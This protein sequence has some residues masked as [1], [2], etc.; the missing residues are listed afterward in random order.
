[1]KNRS[2][3]GGGIYCHE[4]ASPY[5]E[6]CLFLENEAQ[7]TGGGLACFFYSNAIIRR[8]IFQ[9][10][11]AG[12][13]GG[14][15][16]FSFSSPQISD[17]LIENNHA[18]YQGGGLY[19]SNTVTGAVSRITN[20]VLLS[21][22]SGKKGHNIFVTAKM[23]T[24]FR[25]N[26]L[27]SSGGF[28]VFV[29]ALDVDLDFVGNYFG[30]LAPGDLETHI[31]DRHD[32]PA[33]KTALCDPPMELPPPDA[34]NVP[35]E[36]S[37][38]QMHGDPGFATDWPYPLCLKAPIYLEVHAQDRNPYHADWV[39]IRLRSSASDPHGVVALAWET[40]PASGVF[41]LTGSVR[42]YSSAKEGAIRASVGENLLFNLEDHEGFEI[43]CPVDVAKSFITSL[44]LTEEADSLHVVSHSPV[45]GW[46]FRNILGLPQK[47]FR[48]QLGSGASFIEPPVWESGEKTKRQAQAAVEGAN[49]VDGKF[50]T[51][52]LSM[53]HGAQWSDWAQFTLRMNSLPSHS[54]VF[55][56]LSD[57]VV[58]QAR[59]VL[60]LRASSDAEGDPIIYEVEVCQDSAC[61][62]P[63]AAEKDLR[64]ASGIVSWAAS[65]N[66]TD[67]A[68]YYWHARASDNFEAGAWTQAQ[69]FYVNLIEEPPLP[70]GLLEPRQGQLLYQLQPAFSWEKTTDPDPLAS[71][72]YRL[73]VSADEKFLSSNTI[74]METGETSLR[75]DKPLK[76]D[77]SYS[78]RMEAIDNTGKITPSIQIGH[79]SVSTTPSQPQWLGPLA[80]EELKPQGLL[81]WSKSTDPDPQDLVSYRIQ[82]AE[83]DFSKPL[84]D[85]TQSDTSLPVGSLKNYTLLSDDREYRIRVRAEDNQGVASIWSQD[86]GWF[87]FNKINTPPRPV[88]SPIL[89]DS[90]VASA[91]LPEITWK[92]AADP[93]KSDSPSSLDYLI[94]FD[95]EGIFAPNGRQLEVKGGATHTALPE[96]A[97]NSKWFYRL[98]ARD[99]EGA[100]SVWS[101]TK[102]FILNLANDPPSPFDLAMPPDSTTTYQLA[103][104]ELAWQFTGDIDPGDKIHYLVSIAPA[105]GGAP[106]LDGKRVD[107]TTLKTTALLKNETN[108]L[109]WVEARDLAG[110][111]TA[112]AKKHHLRINTTPLVPKAEPVAN[113]IMTSKQ[114]LHWLPSTDPDPVDVLTYHLQIISPDDSQKSLLEL[115]KILSA[116]AASGVG[117]VDMKGLKLLKDNRTYAFRVRAIDPHGAMSNWSEAVAFA[118]DLQNEPPAAAVIQQPS[119]DV[120]RNVMV[121]VS[122][123]APADPDPADSREGLSYRLQ[124]VR[125]PQ[126]TGAAPI[127]RVIPIDT[128]LQNLELSDNQL[129]TLRLRA[130]DS[131]GG[132]S[133]WS[134][135]VQVVVN[136]IEDP[137]AAP[138]IRSPAIGA[139]LNAPNS[140]VLAWSASKDPDY[141]A[142][143][144]YQVRHWPADQPDKALVQEGISGLSHRLT[145]LQADQTYNWEVTAV[146]NT[147]LKSTSMTGYFTYRKS[148]PP[149]TPTPGVR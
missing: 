17:N 76:N 50:Y 34:V 10:N 64:A 40:E 41:R 106:V 93:D 139:V 20:N 72:H 102:S 16:Y 66:L 75:L 131:R 109:W 3:F 123:S 100:A 57:Q 120:L 111:R 127:E 79:F 54:Q 107:G 121:S 56:P 140:V 48:M 98:C 31:R 83:K 77:V 149:P 47:A 58:K 137:P 23:Q 145:G 114:T 143:V 18:R 97:D 55:E 82:V 87:F 138:A 8:N 15:I 38:F 7:E 122:W 74:K 49:L 95:Q 65:V 73:S 124:A 113:G 1:L 6:N 27:F 80:G 78:W 86:V 146:D 101:P 147:G 19:G 134:T 4:F 52:R 105:D 25:N 60:K 2:L 71:I 135:P 5:I 115:A 81:S 119:G 84:L 67:N 88:G 91:P 89:P 29:D 11:K 46:K 45:L 42:N 61:T 33:Q 69:Y 24:I 141:K 90:S 104:L 26:V 99:D 32:D 112:S 133:A 148:Q 28:D 126:F 12:E 103:G 63:L 36:I 92:A 118:L 37:S 108:Y 132:K 110:A 96:L 9:A 142:V 30:P 116:K 14:G 85:E 70:F 62:T 43:S 22:E 125:G 39:A 136:T 144:T 94:Q 51:V 35:Q 21:N 128:T 117:A 130:E 53:T 68:K 59:P 129:W 13:H 44:Q